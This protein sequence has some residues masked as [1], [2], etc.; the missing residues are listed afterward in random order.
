MTS[1]VTIYQSSKGPRVIAEMPY[2]YLCNAIRALE[3]W[4]EG[5]TATERLPE[6]DAMRARRAALD[7]ESEAAQ[8][9]ETNHALD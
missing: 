9:Q 8:Q 5:E 3:R 7:A 1:S 2:P 4:I 6:L